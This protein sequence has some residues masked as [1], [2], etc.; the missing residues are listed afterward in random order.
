MSK[1]NSEREKLIQKLIRKQKMLNNLLEAI[2]GHLKPD[3]KNP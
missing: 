3:R 1:L 2:E